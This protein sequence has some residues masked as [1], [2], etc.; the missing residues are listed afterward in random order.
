M[1]LRRF[2]PLLIGVLFLTAFASCAAPPSTAAP[3]P[4]AATA[5]PSPTSAPA[6]PS[7]TA[8]PTIPCHASP[9]GVSARREAM[10]YLKPYDHIRGDPNRASV[11]LV[12]YSDFQCTLCARL[13]PNL[14]AVWEAHSQNVVLVFRHFPLIN[15]HDKAAL[16]AQASEVAA[17]QG[18]FWEMHDLLFSEQ[19]KW[20]GMDG[21]AFMQYLQN[22]A[23]RLGLDVERFNRD[24]NSPEIRELVQRAWQNGI[25]HNLPT[26]PLLYINGKIYEGPADFKNLDSVVRL[27]MLIQRQYHTCPPLVVSPDET[28]TATLL[29]TAGRIEVALFPKQAPNA[30]NSFVFLAEHGWYDDNPILPDNEGR[31]VRTGDPSGTGYGNAG[32]TFAVETAPSLKFDRAGRIALYNSGGDTNSSQFFIALRPLPDLDGHFTIFGQVIGG[33]DVAQSLTPTDRLLSV[34]I[35]RG[36]K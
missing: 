25:N 19:T 27:Q 24:L 29:T 23:R 3:T 11:F 2:L 14:K 13:A 4:A 16:A 22:A 8:A 30:V 32:Y 33:M 10:E 5:T 9:R 34:Q 36:G 17:R 7:P 6:H 26:V 28:V 15:L 1:L 12:V 21:K 20:V 31:W 35:H 18:K